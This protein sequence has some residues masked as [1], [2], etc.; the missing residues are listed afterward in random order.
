[1][2]NGK[3][4][5][6]IAHP[7][8][9]TGRHSKYLPSRLAERYEVAVTDPEILNLTAEIALV[10][11]R[12][13]DVLSRVDSGESG[14]IWRDLGGLRTEFMAALRAEDQ[15]GQADAM[16]EI[17]NLIG[18]GQADFLAWA[19]VV[20][21]LER[22]RRLVESEQKRRVAMHLA[23]KVEEA[24]DAM[25]QIA[26]AVRDAAIEHIDDAGVRRRV[27]TDVQAALDRYV[28]GSVQSQVVGGD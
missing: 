23:V 2:H 11:S 28:A 24:Y 12:I 21:L 8:F 19:D 15:Q 9:S 1:M 7:R 20:D 13:Q 18:R 5:H 26:D 14:R 17:I 6:G 25:R 27:L 4:E 16:R 3:A 10:D 22:R